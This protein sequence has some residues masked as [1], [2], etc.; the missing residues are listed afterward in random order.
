MS[1]TFSYRTLLR[2]PRGFS[3]D[4]AIKFTSVLTDWAIPAAT[5]TFDVNFSLPTSAEGDVDAGALEVAHSWAPFNL[6]FNTKLGYF[7]WLELPENKGRL[8]RFGHAMTG[9]RQWETKDGILRGAFLPFSIYVWTCRQDRTPQASRG[10]RCQMA[11]SSWT[12]AAGLA[13]SRSSSQRHTLTCASL[14]RTAFRSSL[15]PNQCVFSPLFISG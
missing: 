3:G 9:T 10:M 11:P 13:R 4:E 14:W 6:A 8:N 12:S 5:N 15:P 2:A 7:P 1:F